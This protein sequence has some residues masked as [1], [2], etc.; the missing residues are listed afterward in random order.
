MKISRIKG[1]PYNHVRDAAHLTRGRRLFM[2]KPFTLIPPTIDL[3]PK[4]G[5]VTDQGDE[6]ACS[7]HALAGAD[8]FCQLKQD[9]ATAFQPSRQAIYYDER[10]LEGTTDKDAGAMLCDGCSVLTTVGAGPETLWPYSSDMFQC[11]SNDYYAAASLHKITQDAQ[12]N[13]DLASMKSCLAEGYPFVCGIQIYQ[14]F[15]TDAVASTGQVPMPHKGFWGIGGEQCKGGHAVL[16]I[17]YCDATQQFKFRNSWGYDWGERG[18]FYVPYQ[19]LCDSSL[20]SDRW[21]LRVIQEVK[22]AV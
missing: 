12:V 20:C 11:P 9:A 13:G 21:V 7:G 22:E 1:H 18:N 19:Y 15:E 3:E 8:M 16:C 14:S 5:P 6:G 10:R 2:P 17:G 4:C